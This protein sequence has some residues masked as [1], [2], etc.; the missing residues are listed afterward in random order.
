M[1]FIGNKSL[2]YIERSKLIFLY[3]KDTFDFQILNLE[4][5]INNM[6]IRLDKSLCFEGNVILIMNPMV[7]LGLF[8]IMGI[9]MMEK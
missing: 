3:T 1:K 9:F 7:W 6:K 4:V 2:N 8:I 5:L